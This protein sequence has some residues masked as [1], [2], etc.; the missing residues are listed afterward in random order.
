L[1]R[2]AARWRHPWNGR[3]CRPSGSVDVRGASVALQFK[4]INVVGL[5]KLGDDRAHGQDVHIGTVQHNQRIAIA[6]N[7][8]IHLHAVDFDAVA[9]RWGHGKG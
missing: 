6:G 4:R 3:I 2:A 7:F 9:H 8:A 1:Q 5:G